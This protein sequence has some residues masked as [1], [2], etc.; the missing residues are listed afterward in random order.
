MYGVMGFCMCFKRFKRVGKIAT[1]LT[2][3][4]CRCDKDPEV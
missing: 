1:R 3:L 2:Y 4:E